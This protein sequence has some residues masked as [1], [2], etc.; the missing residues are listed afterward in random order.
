MGGLSGPKN[1]SL[2]WH[3]SKVH[4]GLGM[5]VLELTER[6]VELASKDAGLREETLTYDF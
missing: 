3:F 1:I 2:K 5:D 4:G 6:A